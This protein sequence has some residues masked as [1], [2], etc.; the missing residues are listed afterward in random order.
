MSNRRNIK[1]ISADVAAPV[2]PG[3]DAMRQAAILCRLIAAG[4]MFTGL[5]MLFFS[6]EVTATVDTVATDSIVH[7]S[8]VKFMATMWCATGVLFAIG[9]SDLHVE[10]TWRLLRV[11]CL[12][13]SIGAVVRIVEM[14]RL[15]EW[16]GYAL[17]AAITELIVPPAVILLRRR[18]ASET[19]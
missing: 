8:N 19:S 10:A 12:A 6:G 11:A 18:G 17:I 7:L 14:A 2:L 16:S 4:A 15:D 1:E 9:A 5:V 13:I 3:T